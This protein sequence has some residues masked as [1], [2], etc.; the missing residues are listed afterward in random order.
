MYPRF[1]ADIERMNRIYQ[2]PMTD[3][4]DV[5]AIKNRLLEFKKIISDEVNEVNDIYAMSAGDNPSAVG[6]QVAICDW[7]AD[8]IVYA[9]SEAVR[10]NVP[11][12]NVLR[13]VMASN[14]S[15]LGVDGQPIMKAGKFE[16]GPNYWKPEPLIEAL[17]LG[18]EVQFPSDAVIT[19][20][21]DKA[22]KK[23]LSDM[24]ASGTLPPDKSIPQVHAINSQVGYHSE[25]SDSDNLAGESH[26]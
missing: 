20:D 17:L 24:A 4:A 2:L 12:G 7:L 6:I 18:K 14:M 9:A 13:I 15:K 10:W 21:V 3:L 25:V 1:Q 11:L 23:A 26:P 5:E 16:K 22:A 19:V 8:I